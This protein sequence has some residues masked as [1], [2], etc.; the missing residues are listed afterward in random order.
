MLINCLLV[1]AEK[2]LSL[3]MLWGVIKIRRM[4]GLSLKVE[5]RWNVCIAEVK[6]RFAV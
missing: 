2:E 1:T 6:Y 4:V 5:C 3:K